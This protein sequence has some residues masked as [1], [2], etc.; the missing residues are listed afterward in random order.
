MKQKTKTNVLETAVKMAGRLLQRSA[1]TRTPSTVPS[2]YGRID[3]S[4][5]SGVDRPRVSRAITLPSR[6]DTGPTFSGAGTL[7]VWK[8]DAR[9]EPHPYGGGV[10]AQRTSL[11][12]AA[13]PEM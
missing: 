9:A 7:L 4:F 8:S 3:C 10:A 1:M 2:A 6:S 5:T 11:L 12:D 13:E